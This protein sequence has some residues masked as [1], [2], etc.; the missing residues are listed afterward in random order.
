MTRLAMPARPPVSALEVPYETKPVKNSISSRLFS[1]QIVPE[2]CSSPIV[3]VQLRA[4]RAGGGR[5]CWAGERAAAGLGPASGVPAGVL[6]G[7][8]PVAAAG[9]A[10][11]RRVFLGAG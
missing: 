2:N 3:S 9:R 5:L 10:H 1:R 7:R 4:T 6:L 11:R 8:T